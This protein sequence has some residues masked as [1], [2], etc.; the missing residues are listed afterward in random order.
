MI[1]L[2]K[3]KERVASLLSVIG[4]S[5]YL[6]HTVR[7]YLEAYGTDYDFSEFYLQYPDEDK[8]VCTA[9]IHRYNTQVCVLLSDDCDVSELYGFLCGLFGCTVIADER[10]LKYIPDAQICSVMCKRGSKPLKNLNNIVLMDNPHL[11]SDL[12]MEKESESQRMDFFLNT[13]HQLRHKL[14][15]VYSICETSMPVAVVSSADLA[16]DE[17]SLITFVYTHSNYRGRGLAADLLAHTCS[18]TDKEY[19]LLCEEHNV[20]FYKKC[21]FEISH[22][23]IRF[24]V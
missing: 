15:S 7:L 11:I 5:V 14:I 16:E 21:G 8:S 17:F 18:D 4:A 23:C 1:S 20:Y 2:C 22:Y 13:A 3:D 19:I 24:K 10:M 12:V 9:L 6:S